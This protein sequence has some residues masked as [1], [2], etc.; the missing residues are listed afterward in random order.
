L[1]EYEFQTTGSRKDA[2]VDLAASAAS[3]LQP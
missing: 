2:A 1:E 3:Q